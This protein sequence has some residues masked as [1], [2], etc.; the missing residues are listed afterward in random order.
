MRKKLKSEKSTYIAPAPLPQ[1]FAKRVITL[2]APLPII[3]TPIQFTPED[4]GG[5]SDG[6]WVGEV[7]VGVELRSV[8]FGQCLEI[9]STW[10]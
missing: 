7:H 6:I 3:P 4:I 5:G 2:V 8:L 10:I 9:R 1:Q